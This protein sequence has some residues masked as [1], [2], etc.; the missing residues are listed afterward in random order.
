MYFS[1]VISR[2]NTRLTRLLTVIYTALQSVIQQHNCYYFQRNCI[3]QNMGTLVKRKYMA[4][5]MYNLY[6]L[7]TANSYQIHDVNSYHIRKVNSYKMRGKLI[8]C[9]TSCQ[10]GRCIV[11]GTLFLVIFN[12]TPPCFQG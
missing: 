5:S 11:Q 4:N 3:Q 7:R 8:Q 1:I 9:C 2:M 12:N 10:T 6:R